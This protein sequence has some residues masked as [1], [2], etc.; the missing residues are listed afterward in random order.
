MCGVCK[1]KKC[2]QILALWGSRNLTF[3]GKTQ[4]VKTFIISQFLYVASAV[5]ISDK[6]I[7][8]INKMI[9]NFIWSGRKP[10]LKRDVLYLRKEQ[11][12]LSVPDFRKMVHANYIKWLKKYTSPEEHIWNKNLTYFL[13]VNNVDVTILL[14]SDYRMEK[15]NLKFRIPQFYYEMLNIWSKY[16]EESESKKQI[17]WYNQNL[18]IGKHSF[19]HSDLHRSGMLHIQDIVDINNKPL[20]FTHWVGKGLAQN[21]WLKWNGLISCCLKALKDDK[22]KKSVNLFTFKN[23]LYLNNKCLQSIN[24]KSISYFVSQYQI[25]NTHIPGIRKYIYSPDTYDWKCIFSTLYQNIIDTQLRDFQYKFLNDI[26]IN[27]YRLFLWK[28][29]DTNICDFCSL[30]IENLEHLFWTC[31]KNKQFMDQLIK[32][33]QMNFNVTL[34]KN[35]FFVGVFD[36]PPLYHILCLCKKFIYASRSK[37]NVPLW[38]VFKMYVSSVKKLEHEIGA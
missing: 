17:I 35:F 29:T 27:K 38:N 2:K 24:N 34:T 10:K 16:G 22:L 33:C 36:K 6:Y 28:M 31:I 18:I 25:N 26:L 19:Y 37:Q 8:D 1:I 14:K 3:Y 5:Y 12:G 30:D 32:F 13:S 23:N 15:L 21:N 9:I 7:N 4:V 11:G 20:P